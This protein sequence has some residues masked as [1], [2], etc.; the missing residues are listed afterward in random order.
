MCPCVCVCVCVCVDKSPVYTGFCLIPNE[1]MSLQM[2]SISFLWGHP[3]V[4]P[5]CQNYIVVIQFEKVN[6]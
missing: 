5:A 2:S 4:C 6:I 3:C 1:Q